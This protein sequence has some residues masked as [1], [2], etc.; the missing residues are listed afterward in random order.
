MI[1]H[2]HHVMKTIKTSLYFGFELVLLM[3]WL[4]YFLDLLIFCE[5]FAR[6]KMQQFS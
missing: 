5:L 6:I 3:R 2:R 1:V 4:L